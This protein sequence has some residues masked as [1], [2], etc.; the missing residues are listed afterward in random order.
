MPRVPEMA[1]QGERPEPIKLRMWDAD[2]GLDGGPNP[3]DG[4]DDRGTGRSNLGPRVRVQTE[5]AVRG[6]RTG[7]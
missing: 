2:D 4:P 7:A 1:R 3:D 6:R 5:D